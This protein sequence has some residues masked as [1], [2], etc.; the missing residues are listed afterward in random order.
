MCIRDRHH[1]GDLGLV[2]HFGE[3]EG[4]QRGEEGAVFLKARL[5][6]FIQLVRHQGP[7][8][9]GDEAGGKDPAQGGGREEAGDPV[10]DLSLIHI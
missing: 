9:H 1:R 4:D 5:F 7:G 8:R 6:I 3:E 2:A 10:T